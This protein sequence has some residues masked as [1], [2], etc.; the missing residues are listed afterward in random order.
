M[1]ADND[2]MDENWKIKSSEWVSEWSDYVVQL[3][4]PIQKWGT[5]CGQTA[6]LLSTGMQWRGKD[7]KN[8][9]VVDA[10][11]HNHRVDW[12]GAKVIE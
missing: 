10:N 8:G 7:D 4:L 6:K 9:I 3:S 2:T 1:I 12:E 5:D 11:S